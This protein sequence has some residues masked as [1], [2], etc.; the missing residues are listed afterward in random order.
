MKM[1]KSLLLGSAAGLAAVTAGQA[2]DLPVKAR[3]VEYV[4]ICSL[5]GAGFYYMPGTDLC[6]KVGGWVR[7]E[8]TEGAGNSMTWGPF[9]NISQTRSISNYAERARGYITAD[10]R[11]QTEYGTIRGYISVGVST[12]DVG[13][14]IG[15]PAG[16]AY[17]FSSNRA[18]V[19][20]AGMTAG[21]SQSFYDF[22]SVP[23]AAFRGGYFPASDTGD[24]GWFVWAYTAQL[25]GGF[26]AT[27]SAESRR[28]TQVVDGN[29][30]E[31]GTFPVTGTSG[32]VAPGGFPSAGATL[33]GVVGASTFSATTLG[34]SASS[35]QDGFG[36]YG[37]AQMP[38]I[39]GNLRVDQAWGGA[40]LMGA[41]HEV[42]PLYYGTT[43]SNS[44]VTTGH[45]SDTWGFAL[46]AGL[47]LNLPMITQGDWFQAQAN[48]TVGATRY[49]FFTPNT[50]WNRA[51]GTV[52]EAFGVLSDCVYGGTVAAGTNTS[53]Q[54]TTSYGFNAS[55]EHF[56]TPS[57]HSSFYGS[58]YQVAYNNTANTMLCAI[59][60]GTVGGT[61]AT[62][63]TGTAATAGCNNNWSTWAVGSRLQW[64]VTKSFYL[65]VE[66]MYEDLKSASPN[67]AG[68][69]VGSPLA[70]SGATTVEGNSGAWNVS[71][72]AHRDFLP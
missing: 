67:A 37:G 5:Y 44:G 26:S 22:F 3:P 28:D 53:C 15:T 58:W 17:S 46:G 19:Q 71:V 20:W 31:A 45:P 25:G 35:T 62:Q 55:F 57:L 66:V 69:L 13:T 18:F 11:N 33:A 38:D 60:K 50:N 54:L 6:I 36:A 47:K 12:S 41:L 7:A 72:R 10:V 24:P 61:G 51:D 8:A 14:T 23:A 52:N 64:D 4:K 2:A 63:G 34:S 68:T 48:Y 9:N 21:L 70:I 30:A 65:G 16:A 42:N 49:A 59:E 56:W 40:Q 27:I 32:T 29:I 1:V 43:A 39:I